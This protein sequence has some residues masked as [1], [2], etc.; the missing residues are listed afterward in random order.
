MGQQGPRVVSDAFELGQ[1]LVQERERLRQGR[2][3]RRQFRGVEGLVLHGCADQLQ[4]LADAADD[5]AEAE[6]AEVERG[7]E[8]GNDHGHRIRLQGARG[9]Q[10]RQVHGVQ[11]V[12]ANQAGGARV[13][14]VQQGDAQFGI[15]GDRQVRAQ[16]TVDLETVQAC[17]GDAIEV[18]AERGTGDR[19]QAIATIEADRG[20]QP[21]GHVG[22]AA[23]AAGLEAQAAQA[24]AD[25]DVLGR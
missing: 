6:V 1:Q 14:R 8:I 19:I 16:A 2:T 13:E 5:V 15:G 4:S 17:L 23:G 3:N 22:V 9:H 11:G 12:L 24:E 10:G 21:Q 25:F 7:T 20:I 18:K